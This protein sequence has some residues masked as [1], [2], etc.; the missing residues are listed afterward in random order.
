M[1]V[2]EV[3]E[4]VRKRERDSER[5]LYFWIERQRERGSRN[6]K[7]KEISYFYFFS[8]SKDFFFCPFFSVPFV[9]WRS[10]RSILSQ[11]PF[12]CCCY[13]ATALF[14]SFTVQYFFSLTIYSIAFTNILYRMRWLN[15]FQ[16][17]AL[18]LGK[19][20]LE[21]FDWLTPFFPL[22]F[23]FFSASSSI[24]SP[25][26]WMCIEWISLFTFF[27]FY[28]PSHSLSLTHFYS[29]FLPLPFL[30]VPIM[31]YWAQMLFGP[32]I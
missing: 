5:N 7:K 29:F 31:S 2:S 23:S 15:W 3:H 6:K 1:K 16:Q 27:L 32:V 19:N 30:L 21:I 14:L 11:F 10:F 24:Y 8:I 4:R 18:G 25:S 9:C 12:F 13:A 17:N 20:L 26:R 22:F 28:L